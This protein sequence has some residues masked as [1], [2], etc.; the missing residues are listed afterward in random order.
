MPPLTRWFIKTAIL[1][2]VAA[3]LVGVMI[4]AQPLLPTPA[5]IAASQP[6]YLHLL[7]VGWITQMIFGVAYW[8]FPRE[9]RHRPRGSQGLGVA[10]YLC[11]NLGLLTRAALEPWRTIDAPTRA[12][13]AAWALVSAG[14]LQWVAALTFAL[15]TWRRVKER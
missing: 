3:I 10:T 12:D 4:A 6:T 2:L 7:T 9:S 5:F 1:Y 8:M 13:P 14:V 11:L 15:N